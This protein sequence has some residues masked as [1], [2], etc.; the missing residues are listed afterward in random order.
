MLKLLSTDD[1]RA[2]VIWLADYDEGG[3]IGAALLRVAEA[4]MEEVRRREQAS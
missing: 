3:P 1:L 2:A 4:L